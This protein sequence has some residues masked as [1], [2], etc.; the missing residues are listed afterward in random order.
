MPGSDTRKEKDLAKTKSLIPGLSFSWQKALGITK[1]KRKISMATGI[2]TSKSG[3]QQKAGR[4]F[5]IK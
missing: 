5:K 4:I 1:A 2:P 3:R